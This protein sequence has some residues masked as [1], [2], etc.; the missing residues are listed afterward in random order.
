MDAFKTYVDSV[1]EINNI[2]NE[3]I[4]IGAD[5]AVHAH[6]WFA[7]VRMTVVF[8]NRRDSCTDRDLYNFGPRTDHRD[9]LRV[10]SQGSIRSATD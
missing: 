5:S 10:Q 1:E 9:H 7:V 4:Q 3:R 8:S 6:H 2:R